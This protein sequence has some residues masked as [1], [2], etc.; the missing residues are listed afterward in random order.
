MDDYSI[1]SLTESKNEWCARLVSLLTHHITEGI[2]SIFDEAV[3][4]CIDS[5]EENKYLMTFQNLLSTIPSWNPNTIEIE[6][7]RIE[8]NSG[9][10]YL[11]DLVTCVH[12]IQLKALTCIR[13]GQKQKKIN[14]DIPSIDKFIHQIYINA[15][16]KLYTNSYLFEKDLYPLQI[17][18]NKRELE[19]VLKEAILTTI[20][21]N[22][23]VEQ[24]LRN[25]MEETEEQEVIKEPIVKEPEPVPEKKEASIPVDLS[26]NSSLMDTKLEDL[27]KKIEL[28][29]DD[30]EETKEIKPKLVS[31]DVM[32]V[33]RG[34]L[35]AD[36]KTE[37]IAVATTEETNAKLS[38]DFSHV[39]NVIDGKNKELEVS[40]PKDLETLEKISEINNAKR[41]EEEDDDDDDALVIGDDISFG[42]DITVPGSNS[43]LGDIIEL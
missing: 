41:K 18:K 10:K 27:A 29:K 9:C 32:N 30:V 11:E 14:I 19:V 33:D 40:A 3:K 39:D 5:N 26:Q 37:A 23:P 25:Y 6:R 24:I 43:L 13:V 20:R 42:E 7:K 31:D 16:R 2:N 28:S 17:Q 12:I 15:A 4:L 34:P 8:T 22:V 36:A 38:I 1:T 21:D 35:L